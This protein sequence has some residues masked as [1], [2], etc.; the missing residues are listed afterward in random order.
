MTPGQVAAGAQGAVRVASECWTGE[1]ENIHSDF[2]N[3]LTTKD[4]KEKMIAW[5]EDKGIGKRQV[6]YKLRD[7]VFSRQRYWGEP[8]PLVHC[9]ACGWV[10]VP[11]SELPVTLPEVERYQPT[12]TGESPLA[13]MEDWVNVPCPKCGG[14]AKR[15]T[16]TMPNWAGSSWYF[17]RYC[18]PKNDTAIASP[19]ALKYWMPVDWYNGGMEHTVLH[20]L[21]SRFWNE[22]LYDI[23]A[24]PVK[25]PYA[26]RTSHGIILAADGEKMSKSRG[27]VVNPDEM[28]AEYGADALRAYILFMGPFDQAVSW[29]TNGLVGVRRFL[30]RV[31]KLRDKVELP[32]I[33][34][35]LSAGSRSVHIAIKKVSEDVEAMRFNTAIASLMELTNDLYKEEWVSAASYEALILLLS[36]FAPHICEELWEKLGHTESIAFAEWPQFDESLLV[37]DTATIAVQVNGKLRDTF[38][39]AADMPEA[40]VRAAALA[41]PNV[42]KHLDGKEPKKV[43]Y[44]KGKM[45]SIV[46]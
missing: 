34:D 33:G 22:F 40:E 27:N 1:G 26:K 30:D 3:D 25:E 17:L 37:R 38:E 46:V 16:D 45:V 19:E 14:S 12:D 20:L 24:V 39:A 32:A 21:Y 9:D 15:E 42:Q 43:I 29:D 11:E 5:L 41:R 8:I 23:G 36:P 13:A 7:W 6:N 2:L 31:W 4:A 10:P 18:D 35:Q 44:V 28:I